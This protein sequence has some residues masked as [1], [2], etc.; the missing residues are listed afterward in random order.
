M[1]AMEITYELTKQ[2]FT[3]AYF[4]HRNRT[5]FSKWSR[6][7]FI[8]ILGLLATLVFVGFL[9]KPSVQAARNLA[10]FFALV[11]M[12]IAILWLLPRWSMGRQFTRQPG[13][14]GPRTLMLDASGAHWRW[15]GGSSDV[16]WKNYIR[17]VEGK[18]QILF[19]TSPACFNI[20]P[21][22]G[23]APEQLAAVRSLLQENI[24]TR[25]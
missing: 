4:A 2:D 3:E 9:I 20:L 13:A 11:P 15:D 5:A 7:V 1:P 22:R 18:N 25:K 19:Y 16:E 23:L 21:K 10:P 6:R 12:W 24:Q 14:H 8:W 17:S